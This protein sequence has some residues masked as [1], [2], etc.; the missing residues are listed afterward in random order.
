MYSSDF[1]NTSNRII[2]IYGWNFCETINAVGAGALSVGKSGLWS[3]VPER[4]NVIKI[5]KADKEINIDDFISK[6]NLV[7][8]ILRLFLISYKF[9]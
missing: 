4:Y 8:V 6:L 2:L 5:S 7:E 3:G 9:F 1:R